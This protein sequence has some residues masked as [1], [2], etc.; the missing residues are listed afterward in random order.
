MNAL[1]TAALPVPI[2]GS[3]AVPC[4]NLHCGGLECEPCTWNTTISSRSKKIFNHVGE[5]LEVIQCLHCIT[6]HSIAQGFNTM[7][8]RLYLF[9]A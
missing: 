9:D 6:N 8:V 2:G 3:L 1:V 5:R 7:L 4:S